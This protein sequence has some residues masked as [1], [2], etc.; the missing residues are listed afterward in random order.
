MALLEK[1]VLFCFIVSFTTNTFALPNK[2]QE[3]DRISKLPGQPPVN[4]R[5]YS[6]YVTVNEEHGRA[7]FYWLT[8]A[9]TNVEK[10]RPLVL[11]LNGGP[12]C[13]SV[14]Y[15]A[16]EEIG[17]FRINKTS[18]S[19]YLNKYS[20]NR[21]H[22]VPQLAQQI[23]DYNKKSSHPIINL[24]GFILGNAV[25][26]NYYDGIGTVTYWWSHSMISD[27]T[28]KLILKHCDFKSDE[29]SEK[30]DDAVNYAMN[31]EFGDIDQYSIYSPTCKGSK[32]TNN[33][34]VTLKNTLIGQRLSGYD[35]C[36][37]SYAEKY[38][39]RPDVQKALHANITGISY[40]WTACSDVLI[41]NWKDSESSILP[42]Y[43][44]LIAAGL[45]IW[46]FRYIYITC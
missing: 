46:V 19:L 36:T 32:K 27:K 5:Q 30:C 37:E 12:G 18:S 1:V 44:K 20:W 2:E 24:K 45:R 31:H 7:L 33:I 38:Y 41:R 23:N 14:A 9:T 15:G 28:Y 10:R 39:N 42:T 34:S 35:P 16:S 40:K 22:Y 29:T 3:S 21:G 11:W 4:F 26:D 8:E 17:P 25:T 6:G 43:K 13:S